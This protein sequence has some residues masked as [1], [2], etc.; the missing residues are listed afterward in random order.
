MPRGVTPS[1]GGPV[2][3]D[4]KCCTRIGG[5]GETFGVGECGGVGDGECGGVGDDGG[6]NRPVSSSML[7]F[8]IEI[9][10]PETTTGTVPPL[11]VV[12]NSVQWLPAELLRAI[13][14]I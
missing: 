10:S 3:S 1:I 13:W 8:I 9:R 4:Q 5:V 14:P 6:A 11:A 7:P 12:K 2:N